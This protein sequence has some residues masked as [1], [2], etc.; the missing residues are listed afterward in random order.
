[1]KVKKENLRT[2]VCSI[3]KLILY[4]VC[5]FGLTY[6]LVHFV[7]QRTVVI[8]DSMMGTLM[9]GDNII[10]DKISYRFKEPERFDIIAFPNGD[11]EN[12]IKR[13]IAMPGE[14][15]YIDDAGA[16]FI[17]GAEL[18][19]SYGREVIKD[20]GLASVPVTLSTDE[21]F[22]LGDNRNNSMDSRFKEVGPIKRADIIGR[23]W[24]RIYPFDQIGFV[25][26]QG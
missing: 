25:K 23:A 17:D 8:G 4:F 13:I 18:E 5:V 2:M 10:V 14:T 6:L 3:G 12:Y 21:Y 9:D 7:G 15:V 24:V 16:I 26:H 1:M 20:A 11:N 19:E 22:V